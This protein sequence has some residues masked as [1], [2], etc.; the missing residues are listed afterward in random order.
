MGIRPSRPRTMGADMNHICKET[1]L[2]AL[3]LAVNRV[4]F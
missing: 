2:V 3:D 1:S 4:E